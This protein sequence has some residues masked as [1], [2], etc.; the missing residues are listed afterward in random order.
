MRKRRGGV[1]KNGPTG[2][3]EKIKSDIIKQSIGCYIDVGKEERK[4]LKLDSAE[5][6]TRGSLDEK[7]STERLTRELRKGIE[8]M[9]QGQLFTIEEMWKEMDEI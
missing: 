5:Y 2:L 3:K 8:S 9:K 7:E 6:L 1:R 4:M